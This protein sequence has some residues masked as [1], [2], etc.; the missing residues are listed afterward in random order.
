MFVPFMAPLFAALVHGSV[1]D[2]VA[3]SGVEVAAQI[4][5]GH[6]SANSGGIAPPTSLRERLGSSVNEGVAAGY[7]VASVREQVEDADGVG[8]SRSRDPNAPALPPMPL[9]E[10]RLPVFKSRAAA[11]P[12]DF[13][14]PQAMRRR[15]SEAAATPEFTETAAGGA[16]ALAA[17]RD[18]DAAHPD[19]EVVAGPAAVPTLAWQ[20]P[21]CGGRNCPGDD[22]DRDRMR[23]RKGPPPGPGPWGPPH[24]DRQQG[25]G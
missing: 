12:P 3:D 11:R 21:W 18:E 13:A 20:D 5:P 1:S 15:A 25:F 10:L 24:G 7:P 4:A 6:S 8:T 22:G 17:G 9:L 19:E 2:V 14:S 16:P 23:P